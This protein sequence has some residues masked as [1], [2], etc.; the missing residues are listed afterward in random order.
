MKPSESLDQHRI[1]IRRIVER[2]R[3]GNARVFGSVLHGSDD[4]SSDLDLLVDGEEPAQP[5]HLCKNS[6]LTLRMV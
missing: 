3:A 2:H 5:K 1:D 4:E 6:T